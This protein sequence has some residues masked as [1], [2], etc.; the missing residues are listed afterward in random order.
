M[1]TPEWIT[2]L[3]LFMTYPVLLIATLLAVAA[4]FGVAWS[5]RGH[6]AQGA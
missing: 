5:L 2:A 3:G 1:S 6:I 4:A